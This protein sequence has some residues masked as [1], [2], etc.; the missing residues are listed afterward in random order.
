MIMDHL[1]N[2][3]V[4]EKVLPA[5]CLPTAKRLP[6]NQNTYLC[7]YISCPGRVQRT[8]LKNCNK[9]IPLLCEYISY[10]LLVISSSQTACHSRILISL[11]PAGKQSYSSLSM[12]YGNSCSRAF[13]ISRPSNRPFL[14]QS[15]SL[16]QGSKVNILLYLTKYNTQYKIFISQER[17]LVRHGRIIGW[18]REI[19]TFLQPDLHLTQLHTQTILLNRMKKT[20][21]YSKKY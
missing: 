21:I 4:A 2:Q 9:S 18:C 6:F 15:C 12:K 14:S 13:S 5:S 16:E 11:R 17:P 19:V 3:L 8:S 10:P 7:K 1:L 20:M